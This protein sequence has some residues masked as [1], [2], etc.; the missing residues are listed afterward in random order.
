MLAT[1]TGATA[2]SR[3][4]V[5][6]TLTGTIVMSVAS[7]AGTTV[8][9]SYLNRGRDKVRGI[10]PA[11]I[12]RPR[13][14]HGGQAQDWDAG[15][16]GPGRAGADGVATAEGSAAPAEGST[17]PAQADGVP[18]AWGSVAPAKGGVAPAGAD[19]VPPAWGGVAPAGGR[20]AYSGTDDPAVNGDTRAISV[21]VVH[22]PA[23]SG[24][25]PA[26]SGGSHAAP[27][28]NGAP[29]SAARWTQ[30][31]RDTDWKRVAV[32]AAATLLLAIVVI[33][34]IEFAAG[35]PLGAIVGGQHA[36]G[37]SIGSVLGRHP[38]TGRTQSPSRPGSSAPVQTPARPANT[39][40]PTPARSQPAAPTPVPTV[41]ASRPA[42]GGGG[43]G[44]AASP[45]ATP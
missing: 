45:A 34:V 28:G 23:V 7:S 14:G 37:T 4:G 38:S 20:T 13:A 41:P 16:A 18:P 30:F 29:G 36:T 26:V 24:G 15:D 9:Q 40:G 17:A 12:P 27:Q 32:A 31:R 43:T 19:G 22:F 1:V 6:G 5:A 33:T 2:A 3:F 10:K 8:Y 39:S 44:N 42:S 25:F 35:R 11:I 21:A